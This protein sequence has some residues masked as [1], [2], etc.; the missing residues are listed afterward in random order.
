MPA[1]PSGQSHATDPQ[2]AGPPKFFQHSV[3]PVPAVRASQ[4]SMSSTLDNTAEASVGLQLQQTLQCDPQVSLETCAEALLKSKSPDMSQILAMCENLPWEKPH[5]EACSQ[6]RAFYAGGYRKGGIFGLR[7]H[8]KDFPNVI[9]VLTALLRRTVPSVPFT[10]LA[11]LDGVQSGPHKDLMNS[12]SP[13]I[14]I[15]LSSF[16]GGGVWIEDGSHS[17]VR[18]VHGC[19]VRGRVADFS[20]GH[21]LVPASTCYHQTEPWTGRRVVLIGYCLANEFSPRDAATLDS[22]GFPLP[23]DVGEAVLTSPTSSPAGP[24]V[25]MFIEICAG[26][27]ILASCF[28]EVGWD[29]IAID[30]KRNRFHPLAKICVLDLSLDTSWEYLRWLCKQFPVKWVHAAPPCGT[31]SRARERPG[32]PPPLRTDGEPWGKPDLIGADAD[33]VSA[34]NFLYLALYDFVD[35][36]NSCGIHWSIENPANSLLWQLDP[37][38]ELIS[39]HHKV[40]MQ[41]CAFWRVPPHL[42]V[43]PHEPAAV[44]GPRLVM[45]RQP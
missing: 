41:T 24:E 29:I 37:Y 26:S 38:Q 44:P 5:V 19:P 30:N 22:L 42:E 1:P 40:D 15:P 14:V 20:L 9:R 11:V 17:D 12:S 8:C 2:E 35:F 32:G 3:N 31:S 34:A 33:R 16:E 25:P 10:S 43:V 7:K 45:P 39:C 28:R 21:I 23:R 6:G 13:N 4:G 18:E 27:A 36:L